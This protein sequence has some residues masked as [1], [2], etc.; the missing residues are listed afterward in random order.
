M[1]SSLRGFILVRLSPFWLRGG[2]KNEI[3]YDECSLEP[4]VAQYAAACHN[5]YKLL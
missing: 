5:S 3:L 1:I 2:V 4:S